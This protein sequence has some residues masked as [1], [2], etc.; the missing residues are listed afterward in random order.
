[1][2]LQA[3]AAC[4]PG[5]PSSI[6]RAARLPS[7]TSSA[8]PSCRLEAR[9]SASPANWQRPCSPPME[10]PRFILCAC[11]ALR[12]RRFPA[13]LCAMFCPNAKPDRYSSLNP[14]QRQQRRAQNYLLFSGLWLR[15]PVLRYLH[16]GDSPSAQDG[17][18]VVSAASVPLLRLPCSG[19]RPSRPALA[20]RA[21]R[22]D[23]VQP[24]PQH[25]RLSRFRRLRHLL[26]LPRGLTQTDTAELF[27]RVVDVSGYCSNAAC[28]WNR[29]PTRR[30]LMWGT[31]R[32][33]L[34]RTLPRFAGRQ[35]RKDTG[36]A[37]RFCFRTACASLLLGGRNPRPLASGYHRLHAAP[38][39][40]SFRRSHRR[41]RRK[42]LCSPTVPPAS[43]AW[44][45]AAT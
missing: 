36:T 28:A 37:R 41:G 23:P 29:W 15:A 22:H 20:H 18:R 25:V 1:M 38:Q 24:D 31:T 6:W 40:R 8:P 11:C 16:G 35:C 43:R 42:Q 7:T 10:L 5:S 13:R 3:H 34:P 33:P 12:S 4:Q 39:A 17:T 2:G 45:A 30:R 21:A 26:Q 14:D 44:D 19:E 27:G 9:P 32:L